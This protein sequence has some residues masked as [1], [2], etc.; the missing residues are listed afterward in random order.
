MIVLYNKADWITLLYVPDGEKCMNNELS[1]IIDQTLEMVIVF[2]AEGKIEDYNREAQEKLEYS[3]ELA[4][5]T[6][7]NIFPQIF[8]AG[9]NV[10]SI[11]SK[12]CDKRHAAFAYRENRTCF[13]VD[14]KMFCVDEEESRYAC[15]ILD[16]IEQ[17]ALEKELVIVKEE[18]AQSR[19]VQ[20]E[21]TANVT[22]ELRTPVNGILG[23]VQNLLAENKDEDTRETLEIIEQCC[24][25]MNKIINNILD[26]SKLSAGKFTIEE[27]EFDVYRMLKHVSDTSIARIQEKGLGFSVHI[28]DNVPQKLIGDELRIVQVLNNFLSNAVK[29]THK[30]R[31]GIEVAK[32][33]EDDDEVELFF[34]VI[35]TGIGIAEDDMDK[36]FKDFSQVD[37]SI[38]R[39]FGGTGLGLS[40]SKQ[41]VELMKGNVNVQSEKGKGSNFSFSVRLK[42][43]EEEINEEVEET[44]YFTQSY[45]LEE[46]WQQP[47]DEDIIKEIE[48]TMEKL[49]LC[50]ELESWDKAEQFAMQVKN[51]GSD[52]GDDFR[53]SLVR[54]EMGIRKKDH[55]KAMKGYQ[56]AKVLYLNIIGGAYD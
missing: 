19:K 13:P 8:N 12:Y 22:H 4:N 21:F 14:I 41:L 51:L 10:V 33:W 53:R 50:I 15:M 56:T 5:Y 40:V 49:V 38:T 24:N 36:L 26:F 1:L 2:N 35:D 23:H 28:A 11:A 27:N 18:A 25:N 44:P 37:A 30:G 34:M 43:V 29:F 6:V 3:A 17:N 46:A 16:K 52:F 32:T 20:N 7:F 42:K 45:T 55:D 47:S 54:T 39:E 31:I 9:A 48:S